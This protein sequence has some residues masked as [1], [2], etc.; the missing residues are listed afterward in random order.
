MAAD[1]GDSKNLV[2]M[3]EDRDGLRISWPDNA[4]ATFFKLANLRNV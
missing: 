1:I 3:P 2:A 4:C